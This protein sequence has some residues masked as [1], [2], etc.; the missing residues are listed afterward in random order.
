MLFSWD[1]FW[2]YYGAATRN[3][4]QAKVREM[5][6]CLRAAWRQYW[7]KH[8][9]GIGSLFIEDVFYGKGMTEYCKLA[10][11]EMMSA[12]FSTAMADG[13]LKQLKQ[14]CKDTK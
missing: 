1:K 13:V 10:K 6:A 4:N 2:N 5:E 3:R 7:T 14:Y 8:C 9:G 11:T 12:G